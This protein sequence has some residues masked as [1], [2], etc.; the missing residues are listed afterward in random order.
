MSVSSTEHLS[1]LDAILHQRPAGRNII[2]YAVEEIERLR[3]ALRG[4]S[5]CSTCE[6]CRNAALMTLNNEN[7]QT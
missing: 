2:G 4:V 7:S 3:T 1:R 5:S 6:A